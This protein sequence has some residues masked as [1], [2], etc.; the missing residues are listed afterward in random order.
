MQFVKWLPVFVLALAIG[1][2]QGP[3]EKTAS[4]KGIANWNGARA[5]VM[6]N[7][8]REQFE[9]G[10]LDDARKSLTNATKLAPQNGLIPVLSAKVYIEQGQL[11]VAQLE[12]NRARELDA[13]NAE[14]DYL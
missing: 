4:E 13:K 14:V 12:L 8:A 10:N 7:L 2:A 1:C 9:S 5:G 6:Y 11:E 3:K